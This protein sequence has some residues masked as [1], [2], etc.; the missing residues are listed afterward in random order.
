MFCSRIRS[1]SDVVLLGVG[2]PEPLAVLA[3]PPEVDD[4]QSLHLARWEPRAGWGL[5]FKVVCAA[6]SSV[7][8]WGNALFFLYNKSIGPIVFLVFT[9][10]I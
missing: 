6:F 7:L 8:H 3:L 10:I 1:R 5:V 4:A 9:Q 2:R